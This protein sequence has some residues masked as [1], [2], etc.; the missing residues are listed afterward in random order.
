MTMRVAAASV[1]ASALL[2]G[3]PGLASA[4][5][6]APGQLNDHFLPIAAGALVGAAAG[7]FVLPWVVPATAVAA[8]TGA[9]TSSPIY[10]FIGAS[11]GG[12]L[13]YKVVP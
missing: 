12:M 2:I 9:V 10:A 8:G 6:A 11:I 4:Q 7:F 3:T 5:G 1:I 13:G